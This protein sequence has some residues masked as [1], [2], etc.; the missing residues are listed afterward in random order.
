MRTGSYLK[1]VRS[2]KRLLKTYIVNIILVSLS[3][4]GSFSGVVFSVVVQFRGHCLPP[5]EL[6]S[7]RHGSPKRDPVCF[8]L[9]QF[10]SCVVSAFICF[11]GLVS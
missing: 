6:E 4:A 3:M 1:S 8:Q 5:V 11:P 10:A 2:G 7:F 9:A